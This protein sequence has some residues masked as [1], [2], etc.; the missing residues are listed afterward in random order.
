MATRR[1]IVHLLLI[2]LSILVLL[3]VTAILVLRSAWFHRY[4]LALIVSHAEQATGG[5]V[6]IGDF[7][8]HR[9]GLRIDF[10]RV[11]LDGT[12]PES[13]PPLFWADHI[14]LGLRVLSWL[15]RDIRLNDLE[16][17]HPV[18]HLTVDAQGRSNLPQPPSKSSKS[19]TSINVFQLAVKYLGL[20]NGDIY[21][22]DQPIP[23]EVQ[24]HDLKT[25]V[26]YVSARNAY[27]GSLGYKN[28]SIQFGTLNPLNHDLQAQFTATP[29]GIE[30]S[31]L[32][33][34]SGT[35]WITAK[36]TMADYN[37]PAIAGSFQAGLS[38]AEL[39]NVFNDPT[40]P[41]GMIEAQGAVKYRNEPGVSFIEALDASGTFQSKL[42][43]AD[44]PQ[45]RASI[46]G[47]SGSYRLSQANLDVPS[48]KASIL[49]GSLSGRLSM[50]H[51]AATPVAKLTADV[52]DLSLEDA[53]TAM[54]SVP[55]Q[56]SIITGRLNA[57]LEASWRGSL[58]DLQARSDAT[59]TAA[60][61]PPRATNNLPSVAAVSSPP[62][63]PSMSSSPP[64]APAV[65]TP[66]QQNGLSSIPVDAALHLQY[67]G[68]R[69]VLTLTNTTLHTPHT[70][71]AVNGSLGRRAS[72]QVNLQSNDLREVDNLALVVRSTTPAPGTGPATAPQPLGLAGSASFTGT[73][74]GSLSA[75]QASGRL[76][77]TNL[78]YDGASLKTIQGNVNLSPSGAAIHQGSLQDAAGGTAQFDISVGLSDWSYTPHSPIRAQ[79]A[80][81]KFQVA[82]LER[83]AHQQYP[84][85]GTLSAN[86]SLSGSETSP[87]GQGSV[88]LSKASAW[89]QPIQSLIVKFRGTGTSVHSTLAVAT[90][91]GSANVTLTFGP[92]DQ[93]YDVEV[94]APAIH[95]AK[96]QPLAQRSQEITGTIAVNASG[97]GTVKNPQLKATLDAPQLHVG[98]QDLS[99][100]KVEADVANQ[101]ANVTVASAVSGASIQGQGNVSLTGQ[102]RAHMTLESQPIQIG[103]LLAAF[104]PQA[105][106]GLKGQTQIHASLDGPLSDPE[107]VQAQVEIPSLS[108]GYQTLQIS[109]AAPIRLEY[110]NGILTLQHSELKGTDTDLQLQG[111]LPIRAPGA[112][113]MSATGGVDLHLIKLM[114]PQLDTSGRVELDVRAQGSHAHPEVNG[115]IKLSDASAI[116]VGSPI[117]LEQANGEIDIGNGRAEIKT[118]SGKVGGG[119]LTARG[120]ASY[121][122]SVQ[123]NLGLTAQGVRFLY[124]GVRTDTDATLNLTGTPAAGL[125]NGQVSIDRLSLTHNF[126]LA[127]FASQ[128]SGSS[129]VISS[130][131]LEQNIKLNVAV[132]SRDQMNVESSQLSMQGSVNLQVRGTI[133][134]PVILGRAD[135]AS[136]EVFFEGKRFQVQNGVIQFVNPIETEPVVN[137]AVTTTVQQ[138]DLT[139]NFVGPIDQLRTTYTSNPPLSPVDIIDLLVSGHTTEAAQASPTTPESLL[140]QGLSSEVSSRV[141][142]LVGISSLTIDPQIGGNQTDAPSQLAIQQRVTK[143]L[144]F[145]F[146]TDVTTTQ[147]EVVQVEYQISKKYSMSA[148]R[149]Q[150]GGY[151]VEVKMHKVF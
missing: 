16:I 56:A 20:N 27:Q 118:L 131:S 48:F 148:I 115:T 7:A 78:E 58:E 132:A 5:R 18:V 105:P 66:T 117:G 38:G 63:S 146:A 87:T 142:K 143:N 54:K 28:A 129:T 100:L 119:T 44:L 8:F 101:Q 73:V 29:S 150:T 130:S 46:Q 90:R 37:S 57:S 89:G 60:T 11:A 138:F 133:A 81:Q 74:Q 104:V 96:L 111:S 33:I 41:R 145:T 4:A 116:P 136:G 2:T 47:L 3:A 122:P 125:L 98:S 34:H 106:G 103:P 86:L 99:G 140:A 70:T 97:R 51:L 53:R 112:I 113:Q 49:G 109:A 128:F 84:V 36:A 61:A 75:P 144:F 13:A 68:R 39:A 40:L 9:A 65:R 6:E 43:T 24:A 42:L 134:E 31:S 71:L 45:A 19:N 69:Q 82:D 76:T 139:L 23:L 15:G 32:Q 55:P 1:R 50:A 107:Q 94:H 83:I 52:H 25:E 135:I 21:C 62:S 123:F 79:L 14:G 30:L 77:A 26:R 151:Q 114:E 95:L 141:Q 80:A 72:L 149:D 120:F 85:S 137:V 127:N 12:E 10:Y 59:I 22:N 64:R 93:S 108:L 91:A 67:D 88:Q 124:N 35:S 110:R 17:D 92:K 147:G 126:D 121:S 102:H